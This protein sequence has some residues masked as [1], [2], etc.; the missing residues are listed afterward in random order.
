MKI[1]DVAPQ[2]DG[3]VRIVSEDGRG[4]VFDVNPYL[5][6]EA[7]EELKEFTNF[8]KVSSGGYFIEWECGADLSSDTIEAKW[9][10]ISP[11]S[12]KK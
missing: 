12:E 1:I 4:G 6:D 11:G 3:T 10:L 5:E 7:F 2:R 9:R 8:A